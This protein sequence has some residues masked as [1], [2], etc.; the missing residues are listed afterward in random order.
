M[1]DHDH[2]SVRHG[3]GSCTCG[4][5]KERVRPRGRGPLGYVAAAAAAG[6][7]CLGY[8]LIAVMPP[9]NMMMVPPTFFVVASLVGYASDQLLADPRCPACGRYMVFAAPRAEAVAKGA[10]PVPRAAL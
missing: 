5:C 10:R 9:V 3:D 7:V 6:M 1:S 4:A 2:V 8:P